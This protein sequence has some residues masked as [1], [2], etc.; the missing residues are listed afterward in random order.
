MLLYKF[1]IGNSHHPLDYAELNIRYNDLVLLAVFSLAD[2]P[3]SHLVGQAEY[4]S[5]LINAKC[6]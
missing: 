3:L 2:L 1:A 4:G 6:Y 5:C